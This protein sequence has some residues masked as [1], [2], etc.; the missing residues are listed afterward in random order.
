MLIALESLDA[1]TNSDR[2]LDTLSVGQRY[3][4][5]LACLLG[6][7]DD[8][9]LLDEPT[10]HLDRSSLEFLTAQLQERQGGVVVVTHDRALLSDIAETIGTSTPHPMTGSACTATVIP[11]IA[12]VASPNAHSG[13]KSTTSNRPSMPD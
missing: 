3:R 9:L 7:D 8:F 12:K 4:V 1:E 13:N 11:D 5:R 10:N 6:A 2:L